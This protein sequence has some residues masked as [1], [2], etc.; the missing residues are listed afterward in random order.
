MSDAP[1]VKHTRSLGEVL[2]DSGAITQAQLSAALK[3]QSECDVR[4]LLGEIVVEADFCTEVQ[5]AEALANSCGFPF[6][7]ITPELYDP[8]VFD[9]LPREFAESHAVLP[10]FKVDGML[11]VAMSEPTDVFLTEEIARVANCPVQLVAAVKTEIVKA[12]QTCQ[13]YS[14][15]LEFDAIIETQDEVDGD[16]SLSEYTGPSDMKSVDGEAPVVQLVNRIILSAVRDG[17]SDIHIEPDDQAFR[18]RF[19]VDG[20]LDVKLTP[21]Y[22][23]HAA[24]VSRIKIMAGMDISERRLPQDGSIHTIVDKN[25]IDL[26]IST[27]PTKFGEKTVIRII[28][29]RTTIV[30]LNKLGLSKTVHTAFSREIKKPHGIILVTGPTGSGKSTTLYAVLNEL[31]NPSV[32]ICTVEDPIEFQLPD[33]NQF[34]VNEKIR[35]SFAK[36]LRS[37]LRQDPDVI[38]VGEIRDPETAQIALQAALTRHLDISTHQTNDAASAVTRLQNLQVEPYLISASLIA[39]LGQR[40]VRE[41]C[42]LCRRQ[43]EPTRAASHRLELLGVELQEVYEGRGCTHCGQRGLKGRVGIFELLVPDDNMR[44]GIASGAGIGTLREQAK[45][46]GMVTLFEAGVEKVRA[47]ETT[48]EEMLRVTT[49]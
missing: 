29:T 18:I 22:K 41:V 25:R 24:V 31:C 7:E 40:L 43:E 17:A 48:V 44:D 37:L 2:V 6:A 23:M 16:A 20:V 38:M 10:L 35:L 49:G 5:V 15:T 32:N 39:V 13:P 36:I 46:S 30:T 28:D 9:A 45:A 21:P 42:P 1:A 34:Q 8:T 19:R 33:V 4:K 26:R 12:L 27:L 11:T 14:D 47:G 3:M